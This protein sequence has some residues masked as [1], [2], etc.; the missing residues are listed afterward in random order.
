MTQ[1]TESKN[2]WRLLL[3]VSILLILPAVINIIFFFTRPAH[4]LEH[5]AQDQTAEQ[6]TLAVAELIAVP[7]PQPAIEQFIENNEIPSSGIETL[8]PALQRQINDIVSGYQ[9]KLMAVQLDLARSSKYRSI[10]FL[11]LLVA[12]LPLFFYSRSKLRKEDLWNADPQ[13]RKDE[14]LME[15]MLS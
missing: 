6:K 15:D 3:A 10:L 13:T 14:S 12:G 5:R 4:W 7:T 2:I 1:Q 8:D 11:V 9:Q